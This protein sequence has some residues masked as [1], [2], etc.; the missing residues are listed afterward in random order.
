[1]PFGAAVAMT[2]LPCCRGFFCLQDCMSQCG[3]QLCLFS[4]SSVPLFR[5]CISI[6]PSCH[7]PPVHQVSSH[8]PHPG[9]MTLSSTCVSFPNHSA[10]NP[11]FVHVV[12]CFAFQP[13]LHFRAAVTSSIF[14][15][16][17]WF[18]PRM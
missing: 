10:F 12:S 14:I 7:S 3:P 1:M 11:Q 16:S 6:K 15:Y 13:F 8:L 4:A 9:H 18:G 17:Q 5:S 2:T